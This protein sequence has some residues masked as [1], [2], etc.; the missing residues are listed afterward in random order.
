MRIERYIKTF[1]ECGAEL[2]SANDHALHERKHYL[3]L[4]ARDPKMSQVL[5]W[6]RDAGFKDKPDQWFTNDGEAAL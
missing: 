5:Q 3:E 4:W 6:L 1:C 2:H